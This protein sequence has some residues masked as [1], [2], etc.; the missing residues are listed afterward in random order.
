MTAFDFLQFS[1]L[2]YQFFIDELDFL[3]YFKLEFYTLQ[4]KRKSN[5]NYEK[6]PVHQTPYFKLVNWK[7]PVQMDR[8]IGSNRFG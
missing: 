7:I 1:S 4:Q 2:K 6:N 8:G 3:V 5:S